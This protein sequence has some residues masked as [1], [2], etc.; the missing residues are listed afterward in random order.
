MSSSS[1]RVVPLAEE[2]TPDDTPNARRASVAAGAGV[3][4]V[5][6]AASSMSDDV[7][8]APVAQAEAKEPTTAEANATAESDSKPAAGG[9]ARATIVLEEE[10]D[11]NYVPTEAPSS[12]ASPRPRGTTCGQRM[13]ARFL[14]VCMSGFLLF[15]IGLIVPGVANVEDKKRMHRGYDPEGEGYIIAGSV[16]ITLS[17]IGCAYAAILL[18]PCRSRR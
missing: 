1:T 16:I 13:C 17:V 8:E 5:S 9:D 12:Y 6:L 3:G 11:P 2:E 18:C 10:I 7:D 14:L 15:S 4:A